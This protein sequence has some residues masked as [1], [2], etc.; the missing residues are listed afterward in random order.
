MGSPGRL[1]PAADLR[2]VSTPS[3]SMTHLKDRILV[4]AGALVSLVVVLALLTK[5][6]PPRVAFHLLSYTSDTSGFR[7]LVQKRPLLRPSHKSAGQWHMEEVQLRC[8]ALGGA[9][10]CASVN[11]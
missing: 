5:P 9:W 3:K 2:V 6:A 7:A 1:A 4:V 11:F 8:G 10:L